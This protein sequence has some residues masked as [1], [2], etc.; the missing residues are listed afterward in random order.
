M[1]FVAN[2]G[3]PWC[4][5][6]HN[7]S[8]GKMLICQISVSAESQ[9]TNMVPDRGKQ[10]SLVKERPAFGVQI[11]LCEFIQVPSLFTGADKHTICTF[12]SEQ[13]QQNITLPGWPLGLGVHTQGFPPGW[14][15]GVCHT[16]PDTEPGLGHPHCSLPDPKTAGSPACQPDS[17]LT[18]CCRPHTT[19]ETE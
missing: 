8:F 3:S 11:D 17:G 1:A 19:P 16:N 7:T 15:S 4:L 10:T 14:A 18:H 13:H 2:I 12:F 5:Q 9:R 6:F